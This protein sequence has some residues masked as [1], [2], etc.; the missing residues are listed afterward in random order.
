MKFIVCSAAIERKLSDLERLAR[1]EKKI[2]WKNCPAEP[3][4]TNHGQTEV[5]VHNTIKNESRG[6]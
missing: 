2:Q 6:L 5:V 3:L 1:A 4:F